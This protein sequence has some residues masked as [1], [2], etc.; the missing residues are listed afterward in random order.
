MVDTPFMKYFKEERAKGISPEVIKQEF[1]KIQTPP[2]ENGDPLVLRYGDE[3]DE[4][5]EYYE[6]LDITAPTEEEELSIREK[7]RKQMQTY[8]DAINKVYAGLIGKEEEAGVERL[9]QTRAITARAGLLGGPRG[10]AQ[11]EKT[12]G[13]T[14]AQIKIL[15]EEKGL[16][17]AKIFGRIDERAEAEIQLRKTEAKEA[18]K[19]YITYLKEQTVEAK[20]DASMLAQSG[21]S[22][23]RLK[24]AMREGGKEG[25][26]YEQLLEETGWS[27]LQFDAMYNMS[28]PKEDQVD[29]QYQI[30]KGVAGKN[31]IVAYGM[32]PITGTLKQHSYD[33][34]FDVP[35][36]DKE[37]NLM[38][39]PN[40]TP[41]FWTKEGDIEIPKGFKAGE[42]AKEEELLGG[43]TT[44]QLRE[45]NR[46]QTNVRQDPDIKQFPIVRDRYSTVIE[47]AK[48]ADGVG[49][50]SLLRAYARL[51]D[52]ASSVREEEFRSMASAQGALTKRGIEL[53]G[54]MITGE[55]LTPEAREQFVSAA[56]VEYQRKLEA[57]QGAKDFYTGQ[58]KNFEIPP[59]L[60]I[61]DISLP[62]AKE[63]V[64]LLRG[65]LKA[66]EIIVQVKATGELGILPESEFDEDY[67]KKIE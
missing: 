16:E 63:D 52:P 4:E 15:E 42:F 35:E 26:V 65:Q 13:Y 33:L 58:L 62:P 14:Q 56:K 2:T 57:Y 10:V 18:S 7:I 67:Y 66:G 20:N 44:D 54:G 36:D 60:G 3:S 22:L 50:L 53:T 46:V 61:R 59:E 45:L 55:M 27:E 9:G 37:W 51:I 23:D 47:M 30:V 48:R 29:W 8:I 39:T 6:G 1:A 17:V 11:M 25:E 38:I 21:I 12:K 64:E 32:D 34:D 49:D 28:L 24:K 41:L 31:K 43:L 40:G 5:K 19:E